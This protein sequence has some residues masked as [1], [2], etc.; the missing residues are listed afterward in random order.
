MDRARAAI[1]LVPLAAFATLAVGLRIGASDA[2]LGAVVYAAPLAKDA[3]A[4]ALQVAT[5][6]DDRGVREARAISDLTVVAMRGGDRALWRGA[7]NAD[8]IAEARV[9]LPGLREGDVIRLEIRGAGVLLAEGR[10]AEPR[11]WRDVVRP[12]FARATRREGPIVLD[13]API[14]GRL[15]VGFPGS[16]MV[17]ATDR[18]GRALAD[19]PIDVEPEPGLDV[20]APRVQTCASGWAEIVATPTFHI[21]GLSLHARFGDTD[22]LWYGGVPVA[23]AASHIDAPSRIAPNKARTVDVHA[24]GSHGA[25]Y[26]EVDDVHGRIAAQVLEAPRGALELPALAPGLYWLVTSSEARGAE[27]LTGGSLAR[28]VLVEAETRAN[29]DV[30]AE[31][32]AS[33]AAGFPRE[34]ILD[35]F[36]GK[37]EH[38]RSRHRL[39]AT[40][41]L[42]ALALAAALEALL[43][44]RAA[45]KGAELSPSLTRRAPAGS[46]AIALL[47]GML[48]FALLAALVLYGAT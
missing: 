40:I 26:A 10:V 7:S 39:G 30:G 38:A 42:S 9:E 2:L 28:P 15:A 8:G 11:A 22:G 37:R 20:T 35:G 34:V 25:I 24:A 31:L 6:A 43:L 44:V 48:G 5:V 13:V 41:G 21:V 17:R 45:R 12:T 18:A 19:V 27:S 32:A 23:G 36:A 1:V 16:L 4:L 29:C 33:T 47:A 46:V 14:G 3:R